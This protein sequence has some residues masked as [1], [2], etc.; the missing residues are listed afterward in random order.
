MQSP[1][2]RYQL[3]WPGILRAIHWL[4]AALLLVLFVSAWMLKHAYVDPAF[5]HDWHII[6]GHAL[7]VVAGAR[8]VLWFQKGL[9]HWRFVWP[10]A[11]ARAARWQMLKFYL[12]LGRLPLPNW[13][14]HNPFWQPV[15]LA[16]PILIMLTGLT[17][18]LHD[19]ST[20]WIGYL[21]SDWHALAA[22]LMGFLA[23]AHVFAVILHDWRGKA[24]TISSMLNGYR[25]FHIGSSS[26][27]IETP[28]AVE[29]SLDSLVKDSKTENKK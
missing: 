10:D 14:A 1:T 18:L 28:T 16:F 6:S 19:Y 29:V 26:L 12:S 17:G 27:E 21:P 4:M 2:I 20:L 23:L 15:Y 13:F 5:W 3:V 24:A 9:H 11:R 7:L 22:K 25:Y 8:I